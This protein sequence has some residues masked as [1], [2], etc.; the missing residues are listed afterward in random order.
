MLVDFLRLGGRGG[1]VLISLAP[2]QSPLF[3]RLGGRGAAV[4]IFLAPIQS[5]LIRRPMARSVTA[6]AISVMLPRRLPPCRLI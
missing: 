5:P 6:A 1:A 4:L 2:I 3:L